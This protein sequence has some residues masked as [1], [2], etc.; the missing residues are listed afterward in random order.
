MVK[1]ATG[2]EI[3]EDPTFC[4]KYPTASGCQVES[5][6]MLLEI[7]RL[8]DYTGGYAM[9]GLGDIVIPGLLLSFAHRYD[10]SVGL[11]LSRGYFVYMV[12]GYAVGLLLAN[13]AVYVM[14][15]GQPALLYLVPCTLGLFVFLSYSDGTLRSMWDGPPSLSAEHAGY[16]GLLSDGSSPRGKIEGGGQGGGRGSGRGGESPSSSMSGALLEVSPGAAATA[17]E[18]EGIIDI[19]PPGMRCLSD[20]HLEPVIT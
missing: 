17:A 10:V 19:P 13:M 15:M 9:L 4:E 5:L 18:G 16:D 20:G 12:A 14:A 1:V 3:T 8:W 7:P 6:P 2:G 11:R